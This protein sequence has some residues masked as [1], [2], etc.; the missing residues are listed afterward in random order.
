M[1]HSLCAVTNKIHHNSG[2]SQVLSQAHSA[3]VGDVIYIVNRATTLV[4]SNL[5]D[6]GPNIHKITLKN[7][8]LTFTYRKT[9][10]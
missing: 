2:L 10:L 6:P 7:P 1:P 4:F 5:R 9:S 3:Q 8:K